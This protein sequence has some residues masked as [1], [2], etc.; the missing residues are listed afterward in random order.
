[1]LHILP[2][3][4]MNISVYIVD[5]RSD[6]GEEPP[7]EDPKNPSLEAIHLVRDSHFAATYAK[8]RKVRTEQEA[9]DLGIDLII[10]LGGDGTLLYVSDLFQVGFLLYFPADEKMS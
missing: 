6:L 4:M 3:Q 10:C 9:A 7:V 1:M 8:I 5:Y 2:F